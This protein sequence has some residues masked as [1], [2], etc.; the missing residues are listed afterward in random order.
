MKLTAII[1]S[2]GV[3]FGVATA[4][5]AESMGKDGMAKPSGSGDAMKK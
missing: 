1:L 5:A 3:A 4:H 2:L